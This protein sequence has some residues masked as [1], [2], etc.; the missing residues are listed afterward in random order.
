MTV[1]STRSTSPRRD[2]GSNYVNQ[3]HVKTRPIM[4]LVD[5]ERRRGEWRTAG[6]L[7]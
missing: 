3:R 5:S 7:G 4:H 1:C 6:Q 2:I